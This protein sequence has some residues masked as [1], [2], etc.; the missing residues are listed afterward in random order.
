MTKRELATYLNKWYQQIECAFR[1]ASKDHPEL[2]KNKP[3]DNYIQS[4]FT[5]EEILLV[6]P[7]LKLNP[8]QIEQ[9]KEN[10]IDHGG[11]EVDIR[12][13]YSP[14]IKGM[15]DYLNSIKKYPYVPC[16]E[17]CVYI[18]GKTLKRRWLTLYPF[19]SFYN[20]F[21]TYRNTVDIFH[22]YCKTYQYIKR[23]PILWY[24]KNAPDIGSTSFVNGIDPANVIHIEG[25]D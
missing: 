7:Y 23:E 19:C 13:P 12:K 2:I 5:L 25:L 18:I 14:Y 15:E 22:D 20:R 11:K 3:T 17:S 16:C 8:I 10:F 9:L 1:E 24:K 6:V 4:D 21:L